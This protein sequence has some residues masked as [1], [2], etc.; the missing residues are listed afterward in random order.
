MPQEVK[1]GTLTV[2]A[3]DAITQQGISRVF[4]TLTYKFPQE[5]AGASTSL[6]TDQQGRATFN[7]PTGNFVVAYHTL[8]ETTDRLCT[9]SQFSGGVDATKEML[10]SI[11]DRSGRGG[12]LVQL[13]IC[14]GS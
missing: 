6:L 13:T 3:R 10:R 1:N 9:K 4:V 5:P 12:R 14:F 7:L 8:T 2:I 11:L